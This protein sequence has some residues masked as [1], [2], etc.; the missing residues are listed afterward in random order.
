MSLLTLA[1]PQP[2][3]IGLQLISTLQRD[4]RSGPMGLELE[5][6]EVKPFHEK[7]R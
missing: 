1:S 5:T 2:S 6:T 7:Q 4:E 3:N